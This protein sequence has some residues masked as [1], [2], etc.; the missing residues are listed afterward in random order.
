MQKRMQTG[1]E[2]LSDRYIQ[3]TLYAEKKLY[4]PTSKPSNTFTAFRMTLQKNLW[5]KTL[6]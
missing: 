6:Q 3:T 1:R 5:R 4:I 2:K